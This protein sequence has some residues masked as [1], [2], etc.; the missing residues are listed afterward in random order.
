[1]AWSSPS[2]GHTPR[3][4]AAI[5][6]RPRLTLVVIG[7]VTLALGAAAMRIRFDNTPENWLPTGGSGFE[8]LTEF[9]RRF[10][11]DDLRFLAQRLLARRRRVAESGEP[12]HEHLE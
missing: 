1:M 7:L 12:P 6:H 2:V 9:R 8:D 11:D 3:A 4:I 5:F 10:G